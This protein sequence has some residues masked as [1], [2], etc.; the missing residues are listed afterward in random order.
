MQNVKADNRII[1]KGMWNA[2]T[3]GDEQQKFTKL[4]L[5][6]MSAV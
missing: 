4:A 5:E 3:C 2:E 1:R 6:R